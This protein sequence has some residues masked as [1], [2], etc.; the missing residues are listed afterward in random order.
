M[1]NSGQ[2][3]DLPKFAKGGAVNTN[4]LA[5]IA[6]ASKKPTV[7][8]L[9]AAAK[10]QDNKVVNKTLAAKAAPRPT[11]GGTSAVVKAKTGEVPGLPSQQMLDRGRAGEQNLADLPAL[12]VPGLGNVLSANALVGSLERKDYLMATLDAIGVIP[13]FG[14][15]VKGVVKGAKSATAASKVTKSSVGLTNVLES[16]KPVTS[17]IDKLRKVPKSPVNQEGL[18]DVLSAGATKDNL[19]SKLI[20]DK[21]VRVSEVA[22]GDDLVTKYDFGW[23]NKKPMVFQG[24]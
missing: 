8:Q 21:K 17:I 12:F 23:G 2:L 3:K 6:A 18:R 4:T 13:G 15:I 14:N 11:S 20:P 1:I 9:L 19:L 10:K 5:G 24:P 16:F 7:A 22:V